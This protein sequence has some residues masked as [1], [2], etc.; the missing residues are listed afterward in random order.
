MWALDASLARRRHF[1]TI[2]W[3]RSYSLF[4]PILSQWYK[5]NVA[6]DYEAVRER[7]VSLLQREAEL[8]EVVQLVGP[9]ASKMLS[10]LPQSRPA[11]APKL[12][13]TKRL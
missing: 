6:A 8:Q 4:S 11:S 13:A 3:N 10:A 1:P 7:A 12:L 2:N 5:D 9:D